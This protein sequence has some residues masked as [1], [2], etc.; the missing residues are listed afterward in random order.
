MAAVEERPSRAVAFALPVVMVGVVLVSG[1]IGSRPTGQHPL[2]GIC[3]GLGTSI[4]YAGYLL[5]LRRSS[6][7]SAHVAGPVADA[8]A[9][10]A[11]AALAFGLVFGGLELHPLWPAIGWLAALALLSQTAGWLLITSSLP[12]LPAAVSSLMLLLQPA[13]S[14]GLAAVILGQRPTLL[15]VVG[16]VLT[17]GGA[18]AASLT[19]TRPA[20]DER[21]PVTEAEHAAAAETAA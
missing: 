21:A 7:A 3:Y 17:C 6:A 4:A 14:L 18:L 9:G 13:A 2:A 15:Q 8:T 11:I 19:S 10:S 20:S 1:M 12:R 16:A 5:I